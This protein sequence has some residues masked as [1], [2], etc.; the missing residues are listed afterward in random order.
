MSDVLLFFR[1]DL[2]RVDAV[3]PTKGDQEAPRHLQPLSARG[4]EAGRPLIRRKVVP[5]EKQGKKP[6]VALP[7]LVAEP[8][9]GASE[10]APIAFSSKAALAPQLKAHLA[11]LPSAQAAPHSARQPLGYVE[12]VEG[13]IAAADPR[14]LVKWHS[15][16]CR[17]DVTKASSRLEQE[18][19]VLA[20]LRYG[21]LAS[22]KRRC[23]QKA[24]LWRDSQL[25]KQASLLAEQ[26]PDVL[27]CDLEPLEVES[28]GDQ[29]V[30][31]DEVLPAAEE[32]KE[33]RRARAFKKLLDRGDT[34]ELD[35]DPSGEKEK[36]AD[37]RHATCKHGVIG[38][39]QASLLDLRLDFLRK[40]RVMQQQLVR[41]AKQQEHRRKKFQS[42]SKVEVELMQEAFTAASAMQAGNELLEDSEAESEDDES[43]SGASEH[44]EL[45]KPIRSAAALR[46]A[47]LEVGLAGLSLEEQRLVY[48]H[49]V[50]T[51]DKAKAARN[52]LMKFVFAIEAM[53]SNLDNVKVDEQILKPPGENLPGGVDLFRFA[54]DLV[55]RVRTLLADMRMPRLEDEFRIREDTYVL[56]HQNGEGRVKLQG[57]AEVLKLLLHTTVDPGLIHKTAYE[58]VLADLEAEAAAEAAL[59]ASETQPEVQVPEEP[60][61]PISP[62]GTRRKNSVP[63]HVAHMATEVSQEQKLKDLAKARLEEGIILSQM[64]RVMSLL[65]EEVCRNQHRIEMEVQRNY[66]LELNCFMRMRPDLP[67]LSELY[68]RHAKDFE[69]GKKPTYTVNIGGAIRLLREFGLSGFETEIPTMIGEHGLLN[70]DGVVDLI[71][72]LRDR[73]RERYKAMKAFFEN[74]SATKPPSAAVRRLSASVANAMAARRGSTSGPLA[75]AH[76]FIQKLAIP[77]RALDGEAPARMST[78]KGTI[79]Q[80]KSR[81]RQSATSAPVVLPEYMLKFLDTA[82]FLMPTRAAREAVQ[83]AMREHLT[84]FA[85]DA[86]FGLTWEDLAI[87]LQRSTE[88]SE[89]VQWQVEVKEAEALGFTLDQVDALHQVYLHLDTDGNGSLERAEMWQGI[90]MLDIKV[91]RF[92]FDR[93]YDNFDVDCSGSIGFREWMRFCQLVCQSGMQ[94]GLFKQ[95]RLVESLEQLDRKELIQVMQLTRINSVLAECERLQDHELVEEV[96]SVLNLGVDIKLKGKQIISFQDLCNYASALPKR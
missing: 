46:Q 19:Q 41:L 8:A 74:P 78:A 85:R 11:V 77:E 30:A 42:L 87:V 27:D 70:F 45:F 60:Q 26:R 35:E 38:I 86:S 37:A 68:K 96:A 94:G 32:R 75:G 12:A 16:I 89:R 23:R 40:V 64:H 88:S 4:H 81:Q 34:P 43:A 61:T 22:E 91:P 83:A 49:C 59:L 2:V 51:T 58:V 21:N 82:G 53:R 66:R 57:V 50:E 39:R 48:A 9:T 90:V 29:E 95:D 17:E 56:G 92:D 62:K 3:P 65:T 28:L 84:Y 33:D 55:P 6:K 54:V 67:T 76:R 36:R 10:H 47:L 52:T 24:A 13:Y 69:G 25:K 72:R 5:R 71:E 80:N 18:E 20:I 93:L 79:M 63:G 44:H 1:N 31:G 15:T 7:Q 73:R 14:A